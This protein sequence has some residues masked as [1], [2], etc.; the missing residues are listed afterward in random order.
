MAVTIRDVAREAGVSVAT[1]SHALTGYTDISVKTRQKIQETARRQ[2]YQLNVNGRSLA[3]KKSN[4]IA[5]IIPDL[6]K[7]ERKDNI[8]FRM[9][10]VLSAVGQENLSL[11]EETV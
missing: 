7:R 1:V 10:G 9:I 5:L 6:L 2:G 8:T 3:G 11:Q 4:R